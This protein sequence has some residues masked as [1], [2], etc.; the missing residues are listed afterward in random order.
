MKRGFLFSL[1]VISFLFLHENKTLAEI[2]I[3][4]YIVDYKT[5]VLFGDSLEVGGYKGLENYIA[6]YVGGYLHISYTT[7]HGNGF[8]SSYPPLLYVRSN[9]PSVFNNTTSLYQGLVR[10]VNDS[11]NLP[12]NF[13]FVDIQF[14]ANGYREIV[15]KSADHTPVSD[16]TVSISGMDENT[17]IA[18]ANQYPK[19]NP[20]TASSMSFTPKRLVFI[21]PSEILSFDVATSTRTATVHSHISPNDIG[22]GVNFNIGTTTSAHIYSVETVY[23]TTTGDFYYTWNYPEIV[24]SKTTK[25]NNYIFYTDI[26]KNLEIIEQSSK[27]ESLSS[28]VDGYPAFSNFTKDALERVGSS[29]NHFVQTLGTN[30][31]GTLTQIDVQTSNP[32][33]IYYQSQPSM[34]LYECNNS[35]YGST[36]LSGVGCTILFSGTSEYASQLSTS[37]Q[38]FYTGDVTLNPSK[39]YFF[40][41]QGSDQSNTLPFY[42]GNLADTTDGSC[43]QYNSTLSIYSPCVTISDLY[44]YLRGVTKSEPP[45]PTYSSILFLPG[46]K[47]SRLYKTSVINCSINCEDQLWEPNADSDVE[48]LY[49]NPDG[50]SVDDSIY[51]R[52]VID[53]GYDVFDVYKS[54]LA[55]LEEMKSTDGTISDYSVVPYDWR[56]SLDDILSSG[57]KT[58]DNISY[59]KATSSPYIL[60]EITRLAEISDTGKVTIIA[61]SNGG[62]LTK[63]L[64]QKLADTNDP[65]LQKIDKVI[66][67]AVPHL[68]TPMAIPALLHGFEQGF[69]AKVYTMLSEKVARAFGSNLPSAYNLLPSYDYFTYVDDP[70][71]KFDETMS[72]WSSKYGDV[73]HS[74]ERLHNFLVDSYGRV[75]SSSVD[76]NTP[77]SLRETLLVSA[78]SEH[79]L[80]DSWVP[81]SGIEVI[82]IAGWGVPTTISGVEYSK[83]DGEIKLDP[84]FTI[85]GDGTVVTPSAL[86]AGDTTGVNYWVNLKKYNDSHLDRKHHNILEAN[87]LQTLIDNIILATSTNSLPPYISTSTPTAGANDTRLIYALHSPLTLNIYDNLGNHTGISTTTDRL[88]EQIPGTYFI[89]YGDV[90]YIFTNTNEQINISMAG[91]GAGTFT[92]SVSQKQGNNTISTVTFKDIPTTS[93][94]RVSMTAPGDINT[95]SDLNIDT[96]GNGSIDIILKPVIDGVVTYTP[97]APVS[98]PIPSGGN[99]PIVQG[100]MPLMGVSVFIQP[101]QPIQTAEPMVSTTDVTPT[102]TSTTSPTVS[103]I[104]QNF[105]EEKVTSTTTEVFEVQPE[106][107]PSPESKEEVLTNQTAQ[108]I[109]TDGGYLSKFWNMVKNLFFWFVGLFKK[110]LSYLI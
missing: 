108:V 51:T 91:Y 40:K 5:Q 34:V 49:L 58:G 99:G 106:N 69:S 39:Y 10:K 61:H 59:I 50:S 88:E 46:I 36:A 110:M 92:F 37:T 54:F 65:L 6:D 3:P 12:T 85:D 93:S 57:I 80:L 90:K 21:A 11:L 4:L 74:K 82:E 8:S 13:Y 56:L 16:D 9:D 76:T 15:T 68:G 44:F 105:E 27:T 77:I 101:A 104:E 17:F 23:A 63:A 95:L 19:Q 18:L 42:Y 35:V 86:W 31:S 32:S 43:Y 52:D 45:P 62:L 109:S 96:D 26:V 66:F 73:I 89:Q 64:L 72:D 30:L 1:L 83:E 53:E 20:L 22:V 84:T 28:P 71:V 41:T 103:F 55:K 25:I 97:P 2:T 48:A 14:S 33:Y 100:L 79:T 102:A 67:V 75:E 47:A 29:Y 98:A 81:P 107:I 60:K 94:T 7:S 78:E 87:E 70:V 24:D 38:S